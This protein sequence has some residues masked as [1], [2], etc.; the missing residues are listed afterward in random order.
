MTLNEL[1]TK[2]QTDVVEN[3]PHTVV[4]VEGTPTI[5]IPQHR[6]VAPFGDFVGEYIKH[7]TLPWWK[8]DHYWDLTEKQMRDKLNQASI[9]WHH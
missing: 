4:N 9:T 8:K 7:L 1:E 5:R 6:H 3:I 2:W